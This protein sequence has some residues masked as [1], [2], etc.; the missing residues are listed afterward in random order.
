MYKNIT[1]SAE[2]HLIKKAR[3]LA[4]SKNKSLN[5]LFREWLKNLTSPKDKVHSFRALV[6]RL[7]YVTPGRSFSRDERNER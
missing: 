2:G 1:L 5:V 7:D 6:K 3:E 4:Q